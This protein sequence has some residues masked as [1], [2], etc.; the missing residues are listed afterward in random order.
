[1]HFDRLNGDVGTRHNYHEAIRLRSYRLQ[2]GGRTMA[3]NMQPGTY[4]MPSFC[5]S[6]RLCRIDHP[7]V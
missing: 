4:A 1:V 6:K 3:G 2:G 7:L 5:E